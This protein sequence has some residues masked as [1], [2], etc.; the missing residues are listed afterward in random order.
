[1]MTTGTWDYTEGAEPPKQHADSVLVSASRA[2]F[3][4][5]INIVAM[6]N[7]DDAGPSQ[8]SPDSVV[9]E[10]SKVLSENHSTTASKGFPT[11]GNL[12]A[13][14]GIAGRVCILSAVNIYS[15]DLSGTEHSLLRR[16]GYF[17]R[18]DL[19]FCGT[20]SEQKIDVY[21]INDERS[22][23]YVVSRKRKNEG[24]PESCGKKNKICD[25]VKKVGIPQILENFLAS[26]DEGGVCFKMIRVKRSGKGNDSWVT[27]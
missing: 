24:E 10:P 3:F 26:N 14:D 7:T 1:M 15:G 4:V 22:Y 13:I 23:Q 8:H 25:R 2:L 18:L 20:G 21:G 6:A 12:G 9:D 16:L 11:S 17:T 19:R 27:G 5:W